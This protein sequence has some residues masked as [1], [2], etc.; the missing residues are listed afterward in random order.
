[1]A[2]WIRALFPREHAAHA[3]LVEQI[4]ALDDRAWWHLENDRWSER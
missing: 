1:M 4:D 3:L 2:A